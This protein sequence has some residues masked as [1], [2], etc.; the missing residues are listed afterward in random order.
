MEENRIV[1]I[2]VIATF[3]LFVLIV[4]ALILFIKKATPKKLTREQI[5]IIRFR[6]ILKNKHL[7]DKLTIQKAQ[8]GLD[9]LED[10][11]LLKKMNEADRN[12]TVS[13]EQIFKALDTKNN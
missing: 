9:N 10:K 1:F 11:Y 8:Q 3:I 4:I 7:F 13:K 2:T 6:K 12:D 5:D